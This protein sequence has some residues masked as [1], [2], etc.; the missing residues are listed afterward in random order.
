MN[1]SLLIL[2]ALGSVIG[3]GSFF[4]FRGLHKRISPESF[5]MKPFKYGRRKNDI[6]HGRRKDDK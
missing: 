4:Y 3:F 2:S 1:L 5:M 6:K